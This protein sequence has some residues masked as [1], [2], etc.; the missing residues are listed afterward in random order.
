MRVY[1]TYMQQTCPQCHAEIKQ[2]DFFCYNC[3]KN[4]KEKPLST[5]V[6]TQLAYYAGSVLLPPFGFVWGLRYLKQ[7]D[8]AAKRIGIINIALTVV[9][10]II[11]T[12]WTINFI[13]GI[14]AQVNQQLNSL[15]GF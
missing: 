2:T 1:S 3:G 6:I 4:L 12:V 8:P 11:V 15:Q 9:S 14:N 5:A 13:N 10:L 7:P